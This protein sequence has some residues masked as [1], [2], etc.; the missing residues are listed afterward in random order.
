MSPPEVLLDSS[1]KNWSSHLAS[2]KTSHLV[3]NEWAASTCHS[4]AIFKQQLTL[5]Y[6]APRFFPLL[7]ISNGTDSGV[8]NNLDSFNPPG[9]VV[10]ALPALKFHLRPSH[11]AA[12]SSSL[13]TI[14]TTEAI[15]QEV[16]SVSK[17]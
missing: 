14:A 7:G 1:Y 17:A 10:A 6:L 16:Q 2:E 15:Q 13:D 4:E 9:S 11:G 12:N 8:D 5:N 3:M